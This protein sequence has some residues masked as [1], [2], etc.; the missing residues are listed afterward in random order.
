MML[1]T[2]AALLNGAILSMTHEHTGYYGCQLMYAGLGFA[3][4]APGIAL[5]FELLKDV[6]I[7][8]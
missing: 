4:F 3:V 8:W 2:A 7:P 5:A 1:I 6:Q